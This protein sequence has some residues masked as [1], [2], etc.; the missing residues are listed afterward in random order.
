MHCNKFFDFIRFWLHAFQSNHNLWPE[1]KKTRCFF[2]FIDYWSCAQRPHF[3]PN[4]LHFYRH[5]LV[6]LCVFIQ[7]Q[8]LFVLKAIWT[9]EKQ[10]QLQH[11]YL[12][13]IPQ[14]EIGVRKMAR[15]RSQIKKWWVDGAIQSNYKLL[16]TIRPNALFYGFSIS[17]NSEAFVQ[18][19]A[20][21]CLGGGVVVVFRHHFMWFLLF[22][23]LLTFC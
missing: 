18:T 17:I 11:L 20:I 4:F 15:T 14:I 19:S 23:W 2:L 7:P 1:V 3:I 12:K 8:A 10:Q 9:T 5:V 22:I 21:A 16:Q 6:L 13:K